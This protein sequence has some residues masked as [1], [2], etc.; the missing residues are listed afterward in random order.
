MTSVPSLLY[1]SYSP[2]LFLLLGHYV[3]SNGYVLSHGPESSPSPWRNMIAAPFAGSDGGEM[4][5]LVARGPG[6]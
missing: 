1:S 5:G 3:K 4:A 6:I 2:T